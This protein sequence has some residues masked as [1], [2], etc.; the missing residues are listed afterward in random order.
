MFVIV[1][2][3]VGNISV[4]RNIRLTDDNPPRFVSSR[5]GLPA[6]GSLLMGQFS[7][8]NTDLAPF[9]VAKYDQKRRVTGFIIKGAIF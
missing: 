4:W 6:V 5:F 3:S 9:M 7:K 2:N 1:T 8:I